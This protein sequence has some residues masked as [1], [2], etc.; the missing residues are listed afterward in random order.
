MEKKAQDIIDL[1]GENNTDHLYTAL[2][3]PKIF[4]GA[5]QA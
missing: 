5:L 1:P 4:V 2:P 3:L